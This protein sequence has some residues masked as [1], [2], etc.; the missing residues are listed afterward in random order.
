[1]PFSFWVKAR[2]PFEVTLTIEQ[3]QKVLNFWEVKKTN[4]K[5]ILDANSLLK[6]ER[7]RRKMLLRQRHA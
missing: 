3:L 5:L 4:L 7:E 2:E 1:M 6:D